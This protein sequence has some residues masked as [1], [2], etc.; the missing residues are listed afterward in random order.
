MTKRPTPTRARK[1]ATLAQARISG[2][3]MSDHPDTVLPTGRYCRS[4]KLGHHVH[5][6]QGIKS[7]A[8]ATV[9]IPVSV[10]VHPSGRVQLRGDGLSLECWNHTPGAI[11]ASLPRNPDHAVVWWMPEWHM[12]SFNAHGGGCSAW[13]R[14][15]P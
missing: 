12:L 6:I 2:V 7:S 9:V 3:I 11:Q 15:S 13:Q 14:W 5:W 10:V 1:S 8:G 4:Y